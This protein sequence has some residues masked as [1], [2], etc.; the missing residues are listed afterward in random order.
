MLVLMHLLQHTSMRS[1][2]LSCSASA[3]LALGSLALIGCGDN[4]GQPPDAAV[5]DAPPAPPTPDARPVDAGQI[6]ASPTDGGGT[7]GGGTDGGGTD[8]GGIDASPTDASPADAFVSTTCG[9]FI[10]EREP[11]DTGGDGAHRGA[12]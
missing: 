11:N 7:D 5:P 3:L 1:R 4:L 10:D 2:L 6:D 8:G 12:A 9:S